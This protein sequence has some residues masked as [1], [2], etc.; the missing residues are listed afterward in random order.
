M[1]PHRLADPVVGHVQAT[2]DR[3]LIDQP[4]QLGDLRGVEQRC[5]QAAQVKYICVYP[6]QLPRY[7]E[8]RQQILGAAADLV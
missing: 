3:L 4:E 1:R 7:R 5:L 8:L 6:P 2:E